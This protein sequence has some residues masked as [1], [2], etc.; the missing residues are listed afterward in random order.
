VR[1]VHGVNVLS[2]CDHKRWSASLY[3]DASPSHHDLHNKHTFLLAGVLHASSVFENYNEGGSVSIFVPNETL[4]QSIICPPT[5]FVS[6]TLEDIDRNVQQHLSADVLISYDAVPSLLTEPA[7]LH[8]G[9]RGMQLSS[10]FANAADSLPEVLSTYSPDYIEDSFTS[11]SISLC[12]PLSFCCGHWS[13]RDQLTS[14]YLLT[15][16]PTKQALLARLAARSSRDLDRQKQGDLPKWSV[17]ILQYASSV[18]ALPRLPLSTSAY[19]ERHLFERHW[20]VGHN[21]F[22]QARADADRKLLG[23]CKICCTD[24]LQGLESSD[25]IFRLCPSPRTCAARSASDQLLS[26]YP[27]SISLYTRLIP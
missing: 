13:W 11:Q 6:S 10:A 9:Q 15:T 2:I 25:Y 3:F 7:S 17:I 16:V 8:I 18:L 20:S 4:V 14:S 23:S 22:K 26:E 21:R 27:L 1:V 12:V 5:S 24:I 19:Y